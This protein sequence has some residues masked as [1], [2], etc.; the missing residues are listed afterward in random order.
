[1]QRKWKEKA[2]KGGKIKNRKD[3]DIYSKLISNS[4]KGYRKRINK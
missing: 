2:Q 4:I 1:M 3:I